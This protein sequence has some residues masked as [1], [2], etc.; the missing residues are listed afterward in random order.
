MRKSFFEFVGD[1]AMRRTKK[2]LFLVERPG[3]YAAKVEL[4]RH[5]H[6]QLT[7]LVKKVSPERRLKALD[8][9]YAMRHEITEATQALLVVPQSAPLG[10]RATCP[11]PL[12]PFQS[13]DPS[14][15]R[16]NGR[17]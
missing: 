1:G 16:E 10:I 9:I 12:R 2:A 3:L 5:F 8:E 14:A 11:L 7:L 6:P 17:L 15:S 13:G 4:T